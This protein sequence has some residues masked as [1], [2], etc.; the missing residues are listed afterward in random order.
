MTRPRTIGVLGGMG[1]LATAY[2]FQRLIEA[3]PARCDQDHIPLL[4]RSVPQIPDR[5]E[6]ILMGGS[7]PCPALVAGARALE[8]A[9]AD[10]LAVPCNT[11]H[12]W[13]P[14]LRQA[15]GIPV[16]DVVD[17]VLWGA[18]S[19][20]RGTC[21]ALCATTGSLVA[22]FY[23]RRLAEAGY[24]ILLPDIDMQ[25]A[26]VEAA[27]RCAKAGD[28]AAARDCFEPALARLQQRGAAAAILACTELPLITATMARPPLPVLDT[29]ALLA[30]WAVIHAQ[31][32]MR[33]MLPANAALDAAPASPLCV[34]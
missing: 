7:S 16:L 20:P 21:L 30:A 10:L 1:P 17:A 12:F 13:L 3:T 6:S 32:D 5:S 33:C 4:I 2:F 29:A 18:R 27:I 9:G 23:Q 8:A 28:L 34:G 19:M 22:G 26:S 14:E 25:T 11:A 24:R 31:Q 15:V